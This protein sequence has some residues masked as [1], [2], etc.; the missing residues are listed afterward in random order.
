[1]EAEESERTEDGAFVEA[2][3]IAPASD[4]RAALVATKLAPPV[5]VPWLLPRAD[6]VAQLTMAHSKLCLISA[7]AGWGK[8]SLL[9]AWRD[10][11]SGR[12]PFAFL[13]L[14]PTDDDAQIL[15]TYVIAALRTV[16]PD[17]MVGADETLR[18]PGMEPMRRVV[19]ALVNELCEI[20]QP[21]VL[22]LDDY[23]VL[24]QDAVH[25]SILYLIEHLPPTVRLAIATR[26]DPPFPLGRLRAS[27]EMTEVRADRLRLT[28]E[29]ATLLLNDRFG[30]NL[31]LEGVQLL[32]QR[33][34]G[35]PVALHLA[36]LSLQR[37]P[38]HRRFIERFAGDDRNIVD[39]LTG[40]VL[41]QLPATRREFLLHTSVLDHLTGPLCDAVAD[42]SGSAATLE[43]LE[44][45]NLFLIPLDNHREWYRYHHLFGDW[46]RHEL[47]RADPSAIP[48][49]H[50]R[51][52][53]WYR[54]NGSLESSITHA[55]AA[56]DHE[57]AADLV[58][59][60]LVD[61]EQVPLSVVWGWLD[62]LPDE[63][64][65]ARPLIATAHVWFALAHGDLP[66]GFR[67]VDFAESALEATPSEPMPTVETT[68]A[69]Y[70][71][72]ADSMTG[73]MEAALSTFEEI[74]NKERPTGSSNYAFAVA[75]CGICTFWGVGAR[76]AIPALREAVSAWERMSVPDRY[77]LTGLLAAAYAE[78][79]DWTAAE[80][81]AEGALASAR[82]RPSARYR[83]PD[84]MAAHFALGRVLVARG[85]RGAGI[86]QIKEGLKTARVWVEPF[87]IAYGCLIL[88][89]ALDGYTEKRALVRE[90]RQIME[91]SHDP[92]RIVNLVAAAERKLS[93]RRPSQQTA[94][95]VHVEPLTEREL[96]VLRLLR[97]ELSF[98]EIAEEMYISHNTVKGHAKSIYRKLG[99]SSR[100]A[101][102]ETARDLD[103]L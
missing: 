34:E 68:V 33:T 65:K 61:W 89:E 1:M 66:S 40:E 60:Y 36:G 80:V 37:E 99:V 59:Q 53:R 72:L 50:S 94:G 82:P 30:L 18:T 73:A 84:L 69:L 29:E 17:L 5:P 31:G 75:F 2:G 92:G 51:A 14:E 48:E 21:M 102:I 91:S 74:A 86:S 12:H 41:G 93:I 10:A 58:N 85:E 13:H 44:R 83:F 16:H 46:L 87:A 27:G 88:A 98:R 70:R 47:Q 77:G 19:P 56:G 57:E 49:L 20:D 45:A 6:L 25:A 100:E 52:S 26:A 35:W 11:E 103:L 42:V 76:E 79:G 4:V 54:A 23:Q 15:W 39:Y 63:V 28:K 64:A 22:V 62:R 24:T 55:I 3:T 8:T 32:H 7:P 81:A 97:S 90:A 101:A 95:T 67:W 78:V 96:A 9:A 43:D 38:D 71:A